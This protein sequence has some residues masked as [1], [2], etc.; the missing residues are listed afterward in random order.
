MKILLIAL[1]LFS[2][3][4]SAQGYH[5]DYGRQS[6]LPKP[7]NPV[8]SSGNIDNIN[9]TTLLHEESNKVGHA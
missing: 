9:E 3:T 2:L 7:S 4:A 6:N 5:G 8:L 1:M